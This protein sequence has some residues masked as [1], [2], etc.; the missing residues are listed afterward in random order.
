LK[1]VTSPVTVR[2]AKLIPYQRSV[3]ASRFA[4]REHLAAIFSPLFFACFRF[5]SCFLLHFLCAPFNGAES[6]CQR[7]DNYWYYRWKTVGSSGRV[8]WSCPKSAASLGYRPEDQLNTYNVLGTP[9]RLVPT[10]SGCQESAGVGF[11]NPARSVVNRRAFTR[12]VQRLGLAG[13]VAWLAPARIVVRVLSLAPQLL[14]APGRQSPDSPA[15]PVP[16][17][18]PSCTS[19]FPS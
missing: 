1:K 19:R 6:T 5:L 8:Y 13:A 15:S 10:L 11:P 9:G 17:P 12:G 3:T 18:V 14:P 2:A 16:F 7:S 4:R